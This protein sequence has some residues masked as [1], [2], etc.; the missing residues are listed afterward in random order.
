MGDGQTD[1]FVLT[2]GI[3]ARQH[4]MVLMELRGLRPMFLRLKSTENART[5]TQRK[6]SFLKKPKP[7]EQLIRRTDLHS[8]SL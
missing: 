3:L 1:W 6:T 4:I 2:E 8:S 7:K 5:A